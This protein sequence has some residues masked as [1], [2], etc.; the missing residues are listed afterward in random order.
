MTSH[1]NQTCGLLTTGRLGSAGG[2][3]ADTDYL[4]SARVRIALQGHAPFMAAVQAVYKTLQDQRNGVPNSELQGLPEG[5]LM[6]RLTRQ[7][8][9]DR[10]REDYL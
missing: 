4:T 7:A 2:E 5:E 8:D 1:N 9:Y 10:C 6:K 3:L